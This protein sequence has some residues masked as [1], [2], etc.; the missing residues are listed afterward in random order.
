MTPLTTYPVHPKKDESH[1][2]SPHRDLYK[3]VVCNRVYQKLPES[4]FTGVDGCCKPGSFVE[5]DQLEATKT[6]AEEAIKK[7]GPTLKK[8]G[9]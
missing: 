9:E 1:Y 8:L 3:C 4:P 7:Y 6:I 2:I 5:I